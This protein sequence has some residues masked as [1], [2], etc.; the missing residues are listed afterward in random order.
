MEFIAGEAVRFLLE[1]IAV[2]GLQKLGG[3]TF[4]KLLRQLKGLLDYKLAD[5]PELEQAHEQP[6]V[7]EAVIVEEFRRDPDF[8]R[9]KH[10]QFL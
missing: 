10:C 6:K 8:Y 4:S 9:C 2:G 5:K 3:D 1:Q 7:L